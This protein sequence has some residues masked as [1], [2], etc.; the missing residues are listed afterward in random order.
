MQRIHEVVQEVAE[1][2][3][4]ALNMEVEI[5][6]NDLVVVGATGRIR[7]K[8]GLK[9]ETSHV[10]RYVLE[11]GNSCVIEHPGKHFLCEVCNIKENCFSTSALVCPISLSGRTLGTISLLSFSPGQRELLLSRQGQYLDYISRMGELIAGQ[12]QLNE[13]HEQIAKSE[14]HFKSM[15]DSVSEGMIA[16]DSRAVISHVN[17]AAERILNVAGG[18][19]I[20]EPVQKIFPKSTLPAVIKERVSFTGKEVTYEIDKTEVKINYSAYPIVLD[21]QV[22]GA[23]K[24]FRDSKV[25]A[26]FAGGIASSH[27]LITF[28]DIQGES[29]EIKELIE[30]ARIVASGRS[31]VLLQG[32]SGTGKELFARAI[33]QASPFSKGPYQVINCSAIP[34]HLLESELFGYEEGAFTGARKGG[35]PGKFELADGGTLFLDEIG[36]MPLFLQAKLLRVLESNSLE[37]VGGIREQHF[38]IRFIAATNR[39]LGLMVE[40]GQFRED[41]YYRL[42]VIPLVIPNLRKRK[43]DIITLSRFFLEKYSFLMGKTIRTLDPALEELLLSYN[44]PGNVRELENV[45]EYA[46]NFEQSDC[47]KKDSLPQWLIKKNQSANIRKDI[48]KNRTGEMENELITK[49]LEEHG[50]SLEAKKMI[51]EKLDISLTTL[52]RKIKKS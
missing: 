14:R 18:L 43:K 19:L 29:T 3:A 1:A 33:H 27:E 7:G 32:E 2:I 4:A 21:E 52:Y 13:A 28:D 36:D 5:F 46:V 23:V 25:L 47:L 42:N 40:Q 41:L 17:K 39:E 35:K 26:R 44:W 11:T 12:L 51:A 16:V 37:R 30:Q 38:N 20:G 10:A 49:M 24:T 31:T 9:Q 22:V 45:I 48:L 15:I 34:E 8:I 6:D 50:H